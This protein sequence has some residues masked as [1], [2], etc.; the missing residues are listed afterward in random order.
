MEGSRQ[1]RNKI[2]Q[3]RLMKDQQITKFSNKFKGLSSLLTTGQM[4][5]IE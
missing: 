2:F 1:E 4:D 3:I 5:V